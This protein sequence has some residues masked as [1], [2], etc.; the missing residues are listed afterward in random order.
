MSSVSSAPA[1]AAATGSGT[2]AAEISA[3]PVSTRWRGVMGRES[4]ASGVILCGRMLITP[5]PCLK[6]NYAYLVRADGSDAAL[7]VDPS[8]AG[9]V[10]EALREHKL[11]LA[12]I[13]NTHHHFDHVGGNEELVVVAGRP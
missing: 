10:Q 4:I 2:A 11:G 6:D 8:E 7:V 3:R 9:P 5:I 13:L 1:G 12:G